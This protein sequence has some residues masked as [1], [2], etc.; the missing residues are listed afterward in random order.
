MNRYFNNAASASHHLGGGRPTGRDSVHGHARGQPARQRRDPPSDDELRVGIR[1]VGH[2]LHVR[3]VANQGFNS[4]GFVAP[5]VL[6][7][8]GRQ[9]GVFE[10]GY[11]PAGRFRPGDNNPRVGAKKVGIEQPDSQLVMADERGLRCLDA[12][13]SE[14]ALL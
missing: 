8:E 14:H 7:R 5:A 13:R 6:G 12:R 11:A 2:V 1:I 9:V 4:G 10:H 3:P